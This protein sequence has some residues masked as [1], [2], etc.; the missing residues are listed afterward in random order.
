MQTMNHPTATFDWNRIR[1]LMMARQ[2]ELAIT[3]YR[4]G[5][6][7]GIGTNTYKN[8]KYNTTNYFTRNNLVKAARWLGVELDELLT[9]GSKRVR[10][11]N[12][13]DAIT[14]AIEEDPQLTPTQ[15]SSLILMMRSSYAALTMPRT[16][17]SIARDETPAQNMP[18]HARRPTV[19]PA[20][21]ARLGHALAYKAP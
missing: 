13:I 21:L 7:S 1:R 9:P 2:N 19:H 17:P 15:K 6:Q 20:V 4:V 18:A 12:T 8:F 3:D 5:K 10:H 11:I 16:A 14:L